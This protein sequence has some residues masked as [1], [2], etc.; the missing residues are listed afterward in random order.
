MGSSFQV[1]QK[2]TRDSLQLCK[3]RKF[4]NKPEK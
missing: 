1:M 4:I 3:V 2:G